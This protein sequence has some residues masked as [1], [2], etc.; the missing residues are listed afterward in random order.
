VGV[1]VGAPAQVRDHAWGWLRAE[2]LGAQRHRVPLQL[3]GVTGHQQLDLAARRGHSGD[4]VL[5][6][7]DV[8]SVGQ[9]AEGRHAVE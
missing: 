5:Q 2:R 4:V 7:V 9:P 3:L 1:V 8:C 6:H